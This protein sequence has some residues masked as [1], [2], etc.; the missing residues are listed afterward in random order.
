VATH[1]GYL[2]HGIDV[3]DTKSQ[4]LTQHIELKSTWLGM[5]WSPD[6][7]TLYVSGGNAT[8]AKNIAGTAAPVY[9]FSYAD[10]R[11]SEKP[12]GGLVETIDPKDVWWSGVAYLPNKHW[13]YAAN[14][15]TGLGP[16][17][18]SSLT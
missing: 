10:G 4:K 6:G 11:L 18:S 14:R 15:G 13:L 2:P 1:S 7:R 8:G 16:A 3:F 5:T 12:I 17:M 9:E